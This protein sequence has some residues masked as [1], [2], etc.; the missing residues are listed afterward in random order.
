MSNAFLAQPARVRCI[1][2]NLTLLTSEQHCPDCGL[3]REQLV[4]MSDS[5]AFSQFEVAAPKEPQIDNPALAG[6]PGKPRCDQCNSLLADGRCLECP[7]PGAPTS[8]S[9]PAAHPQDTGAPGTAVPLTDQANEGEDSESGD[10][11]P[12]PEAAATAREESEH[13]DDAPPDEA[14]GQQRCDEPPV[15]PVEASA[16]GAEVAS[17]PGKDMPGEA[18]T[19]TGS[20]LD[21]PRSSASDQAASASVYSRAFAPDEATLMRRAVTSLKPKVSVNHAAFARLVAMRLSAYY[22]IER[23]DKENLVIQWFDPLRGFWV[24]GEGARRL[25]EVATEILYDI[26]E[27]ELDESAASIFGNKNFI[28]PVVDLVKNYLPRAQEMQPLDGDGARGLLRFSCGTVLNFITG[29][30]RRGQPEDRISLSTGY[31]YR[32][33]EAALDTKG[34]VGRLCNDLNAL[35]EQGRDVQDLS[36]PE[37]LAQLL[38]QSPLYSIFYSLFEDHSTAF[39][40]LRQSV[41]AVAGLAGYEEVLFLVDSRGSNGKGTW[42]AVLKAVLGVDNGYYATLEYEKHFVG[43]GMAQKCINNPD[44]AALAGKRFVAVNESPESAGGGQLNT[45]LVK[46]LASGSDDP[47]VANAKYKDPGAF[48]PQCLLAF[49]TNHEPEFPVKDGGFRSRVGYVNMP[50]EWVQEPT[51]EGQR[52]IDPAVKEHLAKMV[53]PEFL[54]WARHLVPGL[55]RAKARII[56]PRPDKVQEDVAVQFTASA[57]A[58]GNSAVVPAI[59]AKELGRLFAD[60]RLK[61]W[62]RQ[63]GAPSSRQEVKEAFLQWCAEKRH[64]RVNPDAAFRDVLIGS[65]G[66]CRVNFGGKPVHVYKRQGLRDFAGVYKLDVVTL[67]PPPSQ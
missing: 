31:A 41:R 40:L 67:C 64:S 52:K 42:L 33:W 17:L 15:A 22:A 44:I 66:K 1:P 48:Q 58:A 37:R 4:A 65:E 60:E 54:F 9:A 2:C 25:H 3:P 21:T 24:R 45:T 12:T 53:Q 55:V 51:E 50:F 63:E 13:P 32:D 34:L 49:C 47:I 27:G 16:A 7:E 35:W 59:S 29:E 6:V 28:S 61:E 5:H 18:S 26:F 39:W 10:D 19:A 36:E 62:E 38:E 46:R 56:T 20:S 14:I 11:C 43:N 30:V 57:V 8:T 23:E